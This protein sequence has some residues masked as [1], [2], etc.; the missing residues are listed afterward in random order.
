MSRR[1]SPKRSPGA[2]PGR[3][4]RSTQR[5]RGA[6]ARSRRRWSARPWSPSRSRARNTRSISAVVQE[7]IA[8]ARRHC[9]GAA[10]R[11]AGRGLMALREQSAAAAVAAR[12]ARFCACP[13]S[14]SARK[15]DRH[16]RWRRPGRSGRRSRARRHLRRPGADRARAAR[17]SGAAR[18]ARPGS[19]RSIAARTAGGSF[20]SSRP[21]SCFGRT[22]CSGWAKRA[23]HPPQTRRS[24]R[25][26]RSG[27]SWCSGWARRN[28]A[29]RSRRSIEV[30]R[31]P[32]RSPGVPKTPKFLEGVINLRGE[33]LP[34]IDQRR[35]F[36]M[37]RLEQGDR[38]PADRGAH[39]SAIAPG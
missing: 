36:D 5:H 31:A 26:A 11:Q 15:G 10:R 19:R 35:R 28:S 34:V 9:G 2:P 14:G 30:A 21:N 33:V 37:P 27:S 13:A 22:S 18:A 12:L 39:A 32:D 25:R 6:R 38:A 24:T 8:A 20:R 7:I 29:C 3:S 16:L 23:T 4:K 1:F 17:A